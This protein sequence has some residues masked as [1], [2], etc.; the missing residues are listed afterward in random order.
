MPAPPHR[1]QPVA[2]LLTERLVL[3]PLT[4]DDAVDYWPLVR[5][6]EILRHVGE[7]PCAS[8]D[9]VRE[10]LRDKPL[11]DYAAYGFGRLAVLTRTEGRLIGWCGLKYVPHLDE[12]DIGYRFLPGC[13]GHG[14]ASESGAAVIADGF[15][16]LRLPRIVGLVEPTNVAS[17][18]VLQKLGLVYDG[19]V[20]VPFHAT[21]VQRY[22]IANP[23]P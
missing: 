17:V 8:V 20:V 7:T 18:R 4:L 3:R 10:L 13:W 12:V 14:Y 11:A 1:T 5:D 19:D 6:P 23:R 22:A 15:E 21:P 16:T 9:A 2:T